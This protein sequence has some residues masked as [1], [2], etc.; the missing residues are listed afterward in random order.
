LTFKLYSTSIGRTVEWERWI[1]NET[2][3]RPD[4]YEFSDKLDPG[5]IEQVDWAVPGA[6]VT[7]RW[8]V[9]NQWGELRHQKDFVSNYIP[10]ANV[11]QY[12]PDTNIDN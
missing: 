10:W 9:Y 1:E 6:D 3:P 4:V 2:E 7:V 5:V 8:T 12:G 11:Y